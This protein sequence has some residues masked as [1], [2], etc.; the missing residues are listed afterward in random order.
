MADHQITDDVWQHGRTRLWD[1]HA[2]TADV[3][4]EVVE[5]HGSS[6]IWSHV[7]RM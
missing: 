2:T 6:N 3:Q 5:Q 1:S 7:D 4:R